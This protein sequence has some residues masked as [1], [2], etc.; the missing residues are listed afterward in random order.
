MIATKESISDPE[1]ACG[2]FCFTIP[3]YSI[4]LLFAIYRITL[5][6]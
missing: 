6:S 4:R 5:N 2:C 1:K 3:Y